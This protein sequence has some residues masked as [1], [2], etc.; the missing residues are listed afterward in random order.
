MLKN[1]R[2]FVNTSFVNESYIELVNKIHEKYGCENRFKISETPVFVAQELK[3]EI[4]NNNDILES[5]IKSSSY[6][7]SVNNPHMN[8]FSISGAH[9]SPGFIA[10]DYAVVC[11]DNKLSV[12]LVEFQCGM[13][14]LGLMLPLIDLY[15]SLYSPFIRNETT[16]FIELDSSEEYVQYL[17]KQ[18]IGKH[19]P[20]EVVFLEIYPNSQQ[21]RIDYKIL[22]EYLGIKTICLSQ[23]VVVESCL[24]VNYANKR[25]KLSRIINRV[26]FEELEKH[27]QLND[28][29][30]KAKFDVEWVCHP[31]WSYKMSKYGMKY[32]RE[33]FVPKTFSV[34]DVD[35]RKYDLSKYVLKPSFSAASKG[36]KLS[37]NQSDIENLFNPCDF[38][39]QKKIDYF[40]SIFSSNG[41]YKTEI[42]I[43]YSWATEEHKLKP[44]VGFARI[45]K[46]NKMALKYN[47]KKWEGASVCYFE[48]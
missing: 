9:S 43:I 44:L 38:L 37:I 33:D 20:D 26:V 13:Y 32:I 11:K 34:S 12:E 2:S 4:L 19:N 28:D 18:L 47:T 21:N 41:S 46:G 24:Y 29:I 27:P 35:I 30:F 31:Y 7:K 1:L 3:T 40:S 22:E 25:Q 23:L 14:V 39:I 5:I 36:V 45:S 15:D 42:R 48:K 17:K 8:Q 10:F 6:A 16:P